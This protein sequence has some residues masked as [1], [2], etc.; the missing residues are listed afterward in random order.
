MNGTSHKAACEA[1]GLTVLHL[2]TREEADFFLSAMRNDDFVTPRWV[3]AFME[4][5]HFIWRSTDERIS[6]NLPWATNHPLEFTDRCVTLTRFGF[7]NISQCTLNL[8]FFCQ[9]VG[10]GV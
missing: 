8:G 10:N 6:Y 5:G 2:D 9:R 3:G 4:G 1:A 7:L